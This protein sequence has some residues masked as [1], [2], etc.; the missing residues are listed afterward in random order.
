MKYAPVGILALGIAC[1]QRVHG[2]GMDV[3]ALAAACSSCHQPTLELP[4]PLAGQSRDVLAAKLRGFRE[5]T[6]SGTVM[7]QL[8]KGYTAD[9]LDAVAENFARQSQPP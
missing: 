3:R 4:P 1:A 9:E 7:P 5:A 2:E 8:A 6:R